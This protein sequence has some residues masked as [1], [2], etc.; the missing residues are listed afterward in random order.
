M[1][2]TNQKSKILIVG[3]G[4][5]YRQ[6]DS[7]GHMIARA[8]KKWAEDEKKEFLN[9]ITSYQLELE[10]V[11]DVAAHE[12]VFFIDAHTADYSEDLVFEKV[13]P[14]ESKGFTTHVFGPGDLAA[15]S[16]KFY[17]KIPEIFILS[18]PGYKFD[19]GEDLS[20]QTKQLSEK[21]IDLLKKKLLETGN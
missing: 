2:I 3:Y 16:K 19:M 7:I 13:E 17:N 9:V 18:V 14:K 8:V 1:Q 10:M 5:P 4:N 20:E 11:E 12:R 6:D 15:L 21:A